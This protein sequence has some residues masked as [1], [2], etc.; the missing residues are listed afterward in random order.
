VLSARAA[1]EEA[2][3]LHSLA[4]HG[5]KADFAS[6]VVAPQRS[7]LQVLGDFPS[8]RPSLGLFFGH[9]ATRLQ[10]R[11]YSISSSPLAH[12]QSAHITVAVVDETGPTG[13]RHL[14]VASHWL[15]HCRCARLP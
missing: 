11:Y 2:A 8:A 10:P 9:V 4:S 3:R 7:L 15:A 5:G 14:G 1:Q 12:P 6:Y 13:R